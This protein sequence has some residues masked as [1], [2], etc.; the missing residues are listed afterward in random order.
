MVTGKIQFKNKNPAECATASFKLRRQ[1]YSQIVVT[2]IL[3]QSF[4]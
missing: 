1:S 2:N 3:Q 4:V